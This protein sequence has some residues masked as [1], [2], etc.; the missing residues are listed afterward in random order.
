MA[1]IDKGLAQIGKGLDSFRDTFQ[2]RVDLDVK[3]QEA[4]RKRNELALAK[5]RQKLL[6]HS[7]ALEDM[8][9]LNDEYS[10]YEGEGPGRANEFL[11]LPEVEDRVNKI[12]E[13]MGTTPERVK[14]QVKSRDSIFRARKDAVLQRG[15]SVVN[16]LKK[17][18]PDLAKE[19]ELLFKPVGQLTTNDDL[20][21]FLKDSNPFLTRVFSAVGGPQGFTPV[22]VEDPQTG[23][24]SV[25]AFNT[26]TGEVQQTRFAKGFAPTTDPITGLK[27]SASKVVETGEALAGEQQK[28]QQSLSSDLTLKDVNITKSLVPA[29]KKIIQEERKTFDSNS[30]D[31]REGLNSIYALNALVETEAK[32]DIPSVLGIRINK[33]LQN[34]GALTEQERIIFTRYGDLTNRIAQAVKSKVSLELTDDSRKELRQFFG[35]LREANLEAL[36][37]NLR[38]QAEAVRS[39]TSGRVS[40]D[41]AVLRIDNEFGPSV[42]KR[43][44]EGRALR[45]KF[46]DEELNAMKNF[47]RNGNLKDDKVQKIQKILL[48]M[49]EKF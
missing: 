34:P 41:E 14:F 25:G 30:K 32:V 43:M 49:G 5:E 21:Q 48:K 29:D 9:N 7:F 8:G 35:D 40:L 18:N 4:E 24:T 22:S 33:F 46:D 11:K 28:D 31:I 47:V 27:R 45:E 39:D 19:A 23:K 12:A 26:G 42:L 16:I 2:D 44:R 1:Q 15:G 37:Q 17:T 3:K 20:D 6:E 10:L 38:R 13:R 36:G